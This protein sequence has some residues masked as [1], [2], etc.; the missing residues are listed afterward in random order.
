MHMK[1]NKKGFTLVELVIVI[2]ILAVLATVAIP[3]ITPL[4]TDA[5]ANVDAVN[6]KTIESVV[7]LAIVE[8]SKDS[9]VSVT[10]DTQQVFN[11][12]YEAEM[13]IESGSFACTVASGTVVPTTA[14]AATADTYLIVFSNEEG[15]DPLTVLSTTGEP[16]TS[17]VEDYVPADS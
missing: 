9:P 5:K 1:K 17:Y 7:K 2:A 15:A 11:A 14:A 3:A 16:I 6:A 13:N 8:A 10:L 4:T 12:V